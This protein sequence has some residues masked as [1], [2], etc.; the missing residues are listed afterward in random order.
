VII[1]TPTALPRVTG[2]AITAERWHRSLSHEGVAV[3]VLETQDLDGRSLVDILD[4]FHPHIVHAHHVS[5]AGALMLDPLV[6]KEHRHVPLVVSPAGTDI[7][8]SAVN[9]AGRDDVRRI[10]R[11]ARALIVQNRET[12]R[13]LKKLLPDLHERIA[14]V[15]KAFLWLGDESYDLRA[16]AGCRKDDILFFMP[17]GIRPVKGNLECISA[18]AK[19]HEASPNIRVL[20]AGPALDAE[21]A[22]RFEEEISRLQSFAR[23]ILQIPPKAMRAAYEGADVVLNYSRSEGLSNALLEAMAAGRPI[24]ASDIPGNR[25]LIHDEKGIGPCGFLFSPDGNTDFVQKALHL[26]N[27]RAL[28]ESFAA[29]GRLRAAEWPNPTDEA[30]ALL[31]IYQ[32]AISQQV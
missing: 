20:F 22:A 16:I 21:Y 25:W 18:M 23:W 9:E 29:N 19:A 10:C 12:I 15:P 3:K 6:T 1:L 32:T 2:N 30:Q 4:R 31:E 8:L 28:R 13:S 24:L 27:D 17:G 14:Y 11:K 26:A 7:N 5:R